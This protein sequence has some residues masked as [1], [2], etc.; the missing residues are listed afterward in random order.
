MTEGFSM[1]MFWAGAMMAVMPMLF[2]GVLITIWWYRRK[3]LQ[4]SSDP[5]NSN[6]SSPVPGR[7]FQE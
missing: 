1:P 6:L 5:I 4:K 3:Q 7:P 2:F